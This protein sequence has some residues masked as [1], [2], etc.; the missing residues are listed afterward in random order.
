MVQGWSFV[1]LEVPPNPMG[2]IH[3]RTL[4]DTF[5]N[6]ICVLSQQLCFS[7]G[8]QG[9]VTRHVSAQLLIA[10]LKEFHR[11]WDGQGHHG[12]AAVILQKHEEALKNKRLKWNKASPADRNWKIKIRTTRG[13]QEKQNKGSR[14][15]MLWW[16]H[17]QQA[18]KKQ[19]GRK[20][21]T[22]AAGDDCTHIS[23]LCKRRKHDI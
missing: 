20:S 23:V 15:L 5:D 16:Q 12:R 6:G 21:K 9:E 17:W 3:V 4:K 14:K 7:N 19:Q 22:A 2:W 18:S 13:G 11:H 10:P 8:S 1:I